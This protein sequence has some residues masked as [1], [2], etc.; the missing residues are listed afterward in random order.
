M[1]PSDSSPPEQDRRESPYLSREEAADYLGVSVRYLDGSGI[2]RAQLGRRVLY[3][4]PDL[5]SH[6]AACIQGNE[7]AGGVP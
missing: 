2:R 3:R 4:R 5:D 7:P 1:K 6:V